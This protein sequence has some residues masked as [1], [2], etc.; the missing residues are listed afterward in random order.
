MT[1]R[2]KDTLPA[3]RL[4]ALTDGVVAIVITLLVLDLRLPD[5]VNPS[6]TLTTVQGLSREIP[7]VVL[8]GSA[9]V[10]NRNVPNDVMLLDKNEYLAGRRATTQQPLAEILRG[11]ANDADIAEI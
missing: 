1:Q 11:A 5:S 6:D 3:N 9:R 10:D 4:D 7:I 2:G 8:S